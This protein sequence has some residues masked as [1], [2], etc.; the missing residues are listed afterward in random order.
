MKLSKSKLFMLILC[1]ILFAYSIFV[2]APIKDNTVILNLVVLLIFLAYIIFNVIKNK[3]YKLIRSRLDIFVALLVFSSYISLIFQNYANLAGTIEYIIKYN[4]IFAMYIMIRDKVSKDN[5]YS[6]YV[7][8]T[9]CIS[10]IFIFILGLDNLTFNI[11]EK[12]INFTGNV[13]VLNSDK[14]FLGIFGYANTT[15]IFML[16]VSLLAFSE[17]LKVNIKK[18]IIYNLIIF[19]SIS[20][21]V[22]SYSRSVW[23]C[24]IFAFIA[25]FILTKKKAQ[26]AEV[27]LRAG[28]TSLIYSLLTINLINQNNYTLAWIILLIFVLITVLTCILS[29]KISLLLEKIKP[30][31]YIM[32]I[33]I[34]CALVIVVWNIGI[35]MTEPLVIFDGESISEV[36]KDVINIQ[37]NTEYNF[38]F[39]IISKTAHKYTETEVYAI[40]VCERNK[41][42]DIILTHEIEVG[43]FE[44]IQKIEFTSSEYTYKIQIK[45]RS[46]SRRAQRGLTI[47]SLKI[48]GIEE[49]L[50]YKFLPTKIVD[51][52]RD[53]GL[54]T[55]SITERFEYMKDSCKL[56]GKYGLLGIGADG[57]KDRQKEVQDYFNFAN[58]IHSYPLEVFCEFGTVGFIGIAGIIVEVFILVFKLIKNKKRRNLRIGIVL[59][60]SILLMHSFMDFELSFMYL[61]IILFSLLACTTEVNNEREYCKENK[62]KIITYIE[63]LICIISMIVATYFAS[64]VIFNQYIKGV[65]NPYSEEF[66]YNNLSFDKNFFSQID[67]LVNRRKYM[68]HVEMFGEII[69]ENT[70]TEEQYVKLLE[71]IKNEKQISQTD[72]EMKISRIYLMKYV[73]D[74]LYEENQYNEIIEKCTN[75][76]VEEI[77]EARVLLNQPEKCRQSFDS[78]SFYERNLDDI[79]REL[80]D[81]EKGK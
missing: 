35:R 73:L 1:I 81:K 10:S 37:P 20:A 24:V 2:G 7:I 27:I 32:F 60:I 41:Y 55:I 3:P 57:W 30:R 70:L 8:N 64:N 61:L 25:Y 49:P 26:L 45:F 34:F 9:L 43:N 31:Y 46:K 47:N 50:N 51:K 22:I 15:A 16:I 59:A 69:S 58:E 21:I 28:I 48:N 14:R 65:G 12:F 67:E 33:V 79:E 63:N 56:I 38:E 62:F 75:E 80:K 5:T 19:I 74:N 52:V 54:S 11:S 39:D 36:T 76:I 66:V 40:Q 42:D 13:D 44:G 23:I 78:I 4:A 18:K 68:S 71:V 6:N 53:I 72:V 77:N 29:E 17:Y